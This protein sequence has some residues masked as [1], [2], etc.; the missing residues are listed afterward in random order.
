MGDELL[1]KV[2]GRFNTAVRESDIVARFGGDEFVI[3]LPD[4]RKADDVG[5][6]AKKVIDE[7]NV[8][9]HLNGR[10][11]FVGASI[12]IT[13][14]PDDAVD[15][16]VMLSNADM[17][18]YLAKEKGR[19]RYQF[20]TPSMDDEV[21]RH[22]ELEREL[23]WAMDRR[24]LVLKYQAVIDLDTGRMNGV[25]ALV[26]W[27]HPDRGLIS[28]DVFIPLAEETGLI[29]AIGTWVLSTA[30]IQAKA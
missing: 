23:R 15:A 4:V 17:A 21:K 13:L 16:G 8:P 24:E 9:F 7:I 1:Q 29:G 3:V 27:N 28:P 12:G 19:N 18:M 14:Y 20:F 11:V 5:E 2:A 10:E 22:M 26:Y 30:A 25:E 6:V